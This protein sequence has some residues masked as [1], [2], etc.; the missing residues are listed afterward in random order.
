MDEF[1]RDSESTGPITLAV[2][3]SDGETPTVSTYA[4]A[5]V[6]VGQDSRSDLVLAAEGVSRRHAWIQIVAGRL[7][8]VDLGSRTG[9]HWSGVRRR[10]GWLTTSPPLEIGPFR[11]APSHEAIPPQ[12]E[13]LEIPVPHRPGVPSVVFDV[14]VGNAKPIRHRVKRA[15]TLVGRSAVCGLRLKDDSVSR[16]H[17]GLVVTSN[18][19][20]VVDFNSRTGLFVNRQ[21]V[22]VAPLFEGDEV[23]IGAARLSLQ[24]DEA[25]VHAPAFPVAT[26]RP[27]PLTIAGPSNPASESRLMIAVLQQFND[28]QQRMMDQFQQNVEMIIGM[29][30]ALHDDQMQEVRRELQDLHRVTQ[31]IQAM[32]LKQAAA[33]VVPPVGEARPTTPPPSSTVPPDPNADATHGWL[34]DRIA[35]LQQER[36]GRWQKIMGFVRGH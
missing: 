32:Q 22:R 25:D 23:R 5:F 12:D 8:V 16:C 10:S 9:L 31:E 33:A 20:W 28:M 15:L 26:Q 27:A 14:A 18:R 19:V 24:V 4:G 1:L 2:S 21:R 6:I 3:R 35:A 7:A 11:V 34:S 13:P 30:K 17:C 29:C 36:A